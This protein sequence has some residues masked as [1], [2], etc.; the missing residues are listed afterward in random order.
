[1]IPPAPDPTV[2]T[3]ERYDVHVRDSICAGCHDV[4]DPFGFAFEHYDGM[5]AYRDLDHG[6]SVDSAV[7]VSVRRDFDGHY[8]DSNQ[9][10][11]VLADSPNVRECFARFM[12][13]ALSG[14]GDGAATPGEDQFIAAWRAA[15][16]TAGGNIVETLISA[17]T[18]PGFAV[19]SAP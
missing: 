6:K 12:F 19:R 17:V 5:G 14:T 10:A 2:T 13:R 1:V 9:L 8:A 11:A 3:R 18:S 4:I 16:A 15:P 7:D